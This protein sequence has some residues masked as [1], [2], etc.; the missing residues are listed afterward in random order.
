MEKNIIEFVRRAANGSL[1]LYSAADTPLTRYWREC[2]PPVVRPIA[3]SSL[4]QLVPSSGYLHVRMDDLQH[5]M[6]VASFLNLFLYPVE[7]F[8]VPTLLSLQCAIIQCQLGLLNQNLDCA[9]IMGR[10]FGFMS[11]DRSAGRWDTS[12]SD[13][14]SENNR[15]SGAF[16]LNKDSSPP[17]TNFLPSTNNVD[18]TAKYS[19]FRL[20]DREYSSSRWKTG[21][22][23]ALEMPFDDWNSFAVDANQLD[24]F[25]KIKSRQPIY[26]N[27][28]RV[29]K[30]I[31]NTT[32]DENPQ[33]DTTT[34]TPPDHHQFEEDQKTEELQ[35][36][37]GLLDPEEL[38]QV[39]AF[40]SDTSA[41]AA[42]YHQQ[43]EEQLSTKEF[44]Q[45]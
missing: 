34:F 11:K 43:G 27:E 42:S 18:V 25:N 37:L 4:E 22:S 5:L 14:K 19:A 20:G 9:G 1:D 3:G 32:D 17:N 33:H 35:A 44:N 30:M 2:M 40:I 16:G 15:F 23:S 36:I 6:A 24:R 29:S 21:L 45:N 41:A 26:S 31:D 38:I 8:Y 39:M 13:L 28:E 12:R 10:Y 7:N